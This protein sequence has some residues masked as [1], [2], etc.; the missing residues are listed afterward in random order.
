MNSFT[1]RI[2][3]QSRVSIALALGIAAV[4][5]VVLALTY[6]AVI[7]L[8]KL[9]GNLV[10]FLALPPLIVYL[11]ALWFAAPV[12]VIQISNGQLALTDGRNE[13]D[14]LM[15]HDIAHIRITGMAHTIEVFD[16]TGRRRL[17]LTPHGVQ[18]QG[19][20][21]LDYLRTLMPHIEHREEL[22]NRKNKFTNRYVDFP[23]PAPR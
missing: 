22:G 23:P 8:A 4:C 12:R 14:R 18:G 16:R 7:E 5:G 21:I 13:L 17:A 6:K 3:P 2:K 19:D 15:L 9:S 20:K 10:I 11:V 1:F